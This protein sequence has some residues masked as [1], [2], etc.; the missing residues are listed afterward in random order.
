M[1]F[2]L[3]PHG[4]IAGMKQDIEIKARADLPIYLGSI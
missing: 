1:L 2:E 3:E 4:V